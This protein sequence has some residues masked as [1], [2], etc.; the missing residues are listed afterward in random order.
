MKQQIDN[1]IANVL[2]DEGEVYLPQVG[3]LILLRHSA[4]LI[5][6]SELQRPYYELRYTQEER[7]LS[8]TA[9]ISRVANV[10]EERASDIYA[11]WFTQSL[12]D[13]ILTIGG[14]CAIAG[15]K[16]KI[17]SQFR[18]HIN[19][20]GEGSIKLQPRRNNLA[21][22]A[23]AATFLVLLAGGG[24]YYYF[25]QPI[26]NTAEQV[27]VIEQSAP[28][29]ATPT[30][31]VA[32]I[33]TEPNA[34]SLSVLTA[35]EI[36]TKEVADS[37]VIVSPATDSLA[38]AQE[39]TTKEAVTEAITEANAESIAATPNH[40][41]HPM[42]KGYSYAVWGVYKELKNV[43]EAMEWLGEKFPQVEAKV[44]K[45][46]QRYL[47]AL[48]EV[49]SRNACGHKVSSWK[50]QWKSFRSVWVYTR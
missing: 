48:Y 18:K 8:I 2:L 35:E 6:N 29:V 21:I 33:L 25:N 10:S 4:K 46:D 15:G 22:V 16:A 19:P 26:S 3:T 40:T 43:D 37:V 28:E 34:D 7:G 5:S 39:P 20:K 32:P 17:D 38:T 41:I 24:A 31:V 13:N 27:V 44:Y 23:A 9:H 47:I 11:E 14:V 49:K 36:T 50:R 45:Y 30:E 12:R 42:K 1:L